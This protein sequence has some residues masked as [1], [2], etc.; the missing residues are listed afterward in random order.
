MRNQ[1]IEYWALKIVDLVSKSKKVEDSRIELKADWPEDSNKIA[2]RIAGLANAAGGEPVLLLVGLSEETGIT[3]IPSGKDTASWW[4]KVIA[5][6]EGGHPAMKDLRLEAHEKPILVLCFET[7]NAPYVVKNAAFGSS[8]TAVSLEVPFREGTSVRSARRS[9]ILRILVPKIKMPVAEII[10]VGIN[11]KIA[12]YGDLRIGYDVNFSI[13]LTP[14]DQTPIGFPLHKI[15]GYLE[16]E[17]GKTT[18]LIIQHINVDPKN[19]DIQKTSSGIIFK[20][21]D[22]MTIY[23]YARPDPEEAFISENVS[24]VFKLF[25][26]TLSSPV[27]VT[28]GFKSKLT[29][30]MLAEKLA[31]Q[32]KQQMENR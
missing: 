4:P 10:R 15:E 18:P 12:V 32:S 31:E 9:D 26:P 29:I 30:E 11:E 19:P 27:V 21:P 13:Y 14:V 1:E 7:D 6:F 20:G 16:F 17:S 28:T 22:T 3:G 24:L 25:S 8:P 5:E 2:R 23:A